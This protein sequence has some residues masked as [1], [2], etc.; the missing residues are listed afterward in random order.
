[1]LSNNYN[2]AILV[3]VQ[4]LHENDKWIICVSK[5]VYTLF[6]KKLFLFHTALLNVSFMTE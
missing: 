4:R 1:M 2:Q 5:G 3:D 6:K